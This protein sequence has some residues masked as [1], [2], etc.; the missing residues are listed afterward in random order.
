MSMEIRYQQGNLRAMN[1]DGMLSGC[2]NDE[3][4]YN[5]NSII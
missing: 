2:D 3:G 4:D 5:Y 1:D